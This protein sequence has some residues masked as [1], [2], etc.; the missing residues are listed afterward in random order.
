MYV[1]PKVAN[2]TDM[3]LF[4]RTAN[5]RGGTARGVGGQHG[6]GG[7]AA[8]PPDVDVT[9]SELVSISLLFL[10]LCGRNVWSLCLVSAPF[11]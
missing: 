10:S 11:N 8:I 2:P 5:Q 3:L 4:K 1:Y 7:M 9:V 6:S